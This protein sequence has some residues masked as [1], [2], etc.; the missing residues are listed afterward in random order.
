MKTLNK[1]YP[2]E[3]IQSA[4]RYAMDRL[5]IPSE[6]LME[7]AGIACADMA[8]SMSAVGDEVAILAGTGSNGGD[9]F[10]VARHLA[11][12]GRRV[13]VFLAGDESRLS[14]AASANYSILTKLHIPCVKTED[15]SD[16]ELADSVGRASLVIDALLGT[17]AKGAPRGEVLRAVCSARKA[18]QI[19]AID[20]P[21]GVDLSDG[22][23]LG[24]VIK[25][26]VTVTMIAGKIGH[27]VSP[28]RIYSGDLV[29][30][31]IGVDDEVIVRD[32]EE[33]SMDLI[34]RRWVEER[35]PSTRLD[36][37]KGSRGG[38]LIIAG[39]LR[40]PG[41]AALASMGALRGGAG[42]CVLAAP[43]IVRPY[44]SSLPEVIFE[45]MNTPDELSAILDR[46]R[47]RCSVAVVGPGLDRNGLSEEIFSCFWEDGGYKTVVDGDGLFFLASRKDRR[48]NLL[49]TPHEGEA[50]RLLDW[51][52]SDV[53]YRR[54][55]A[56]TELGEK[57]GL[58]LLKGYGTLISDGRRRS[59][60]SS[61]NQALSIP[62][63]GDVLSGLV[64]AM[65]ARGLSSM[66]AG[67][68]ASWIHG[69]SGENLSEK[70]VDGLRAS[71]IADEIP[72]VM[73]E[74]L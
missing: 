45:P 38:V 59:V 67:A 20:G 21:S 15:L 22:T 63:S 16:T 24:E 41:A 2:S 27:F 6:I 19:L 70:S 60:I 56:V 33:L 55:S 66:E 4:D 50:A 3:V 61:G 72:S 64:G 29:I 39:S 18:R 44:I 1:I 52:P 26:D 25:A 31:H 40:Y 54:L 9:G 36:A 7:N 65:W 71:E 42:L 11:R 68:M 49:I 35:Y 10:V 69:V 30:A 34:D 62:G 23:V 46:W 47:E 17:G 8:A 57:Y 48:E 51:T 74:V 73:G 53:A 14:G 58:C 5:G 13:S 43:E 12:M 28:G 32:D 37:H